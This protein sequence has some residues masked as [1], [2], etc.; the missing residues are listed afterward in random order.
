MED[1]VGI[2]E[3]GKMKKLRKTCWLV[4]IF[5]I[6]CATPTFAKDYSSQDL[7]NIANH[8]IE[9]QTDKTKETNIF[10]SNLLLN[11]G[12]ESSDWFVIGVS[13]LGK[14]ANYLD[15]QALLSKNIETR[16]QEKNTLSKAK[17]TEWHRTGL[18]YLA[19]G[20]NPTELSFDGKETINL[21]NDGTYNRAQKMALDKQGTNGLIFALMLLDSMNYQVPDKAEDTRKDIVTNLLNA[22]NKDGGFPLAKSSD[23]DIDI[24]AMALTALAPYYNS[25]ESF[26]LNEDKKIEVK[27]AVESGLTFLSEQQTDEGGFESWGT[28]NPESATQVILALTALNI[29]PQKDERFIKKNTHLIDFLITFQL[30]DGGFVHSFEYDENNPSSKPN[31]SNTMASEQVLTALGSLIRQQNKMRHFYDFRPELSKEIASQLNE[32]NKSIKNLDKKETKKTDV[33]SAYDLYSS[34]PTEEKRY[35]ENYKLL[36]QKMKEVNLSASQTDFTTSTIG[37]SLN[38]T[39]SITEISSKKPVQE[40]E[41]ISDKIAELK[42]VN[43][44]NLSLS[45]LPLVYSTYYLA[46][47]TGKDNISQEDLN[48]VKDMMT[49]LDTK[50]EQI[51][52]I[53]QKIKADY[54]PMDKLGAK[55]Y[56]KV[57]KTLKSLDTLSEED[58]QLVFGYEDLEKNVAHTSSL[59]RSGIISVV[60]L[61]IIIIGLIILSKNRKKR[62]KDKK[63]KMM[64]FDDDDEEYED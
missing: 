10:D 26:T 38:Q 9:W 47:T 56:F 24:T 45:H 33:T 54:Y 49:Q 19:S 23:S 27:E 22:Q 2:M 17:A 53:G 46:N 32:V 14:E 41:D 36:S 4:L 57:K 34:V 52:E 58:K 7:E 1:L 8:I 43:S 31:E 61:I 44:E 50:Q 30:K 63:K 13:R 59:I 12:S 64:M 37:K 48:L 5:L 42:K 6:G 51:D 3:T 40:N 11:A 25:E 16:Y 18:A 15:Y 55:D 62:K 20:G 29:D 60:V 28:P 39:G 35:V 21:V